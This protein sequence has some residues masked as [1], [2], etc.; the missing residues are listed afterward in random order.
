MDTLNPAD[1]GG[2]G[3]EDEYPSS[4]GDEVSQTVRGMSFFFFSRCS[5]TG[6]DSDWTKCPL[7]SRV[8]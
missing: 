6:S 4:S 8:E 3:G 2:V 1:L 7:L 5:P